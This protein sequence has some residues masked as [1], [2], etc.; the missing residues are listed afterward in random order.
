M[1]PREANVLLTKAALLDPRM[2]RVDLAEQADM[3]TAWAS[4]LTRGGVDLP[5]ALTAVEEHY[6]TS[7]EAITVA[8]IVAAAG[9]PSLPGVVDITAELEA[10]WAAEPK[11][12]EGP[13]RMRPDGGWPEQ[14]NDGEDEA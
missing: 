11:A 14:I 1:T 12:I 10:E 3:A 6:L 13:D 5:A 7:R 4:A 2:K 8:D 9:V